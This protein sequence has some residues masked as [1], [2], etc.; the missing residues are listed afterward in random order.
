LFV[1]RPESSEGIGR[2]VVVSEDMM[3]IKTIKLL[4]ELPYVLEVCLHVG[5]TVIRLPHDLVDD[6]LRVAMHIKLLDPE[7]GGDAEAINK[8]LIFRHIVC[9]MEM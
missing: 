5:V 4:L 3:K 2:L 9:R 1:T 7:L 8:G 6:E